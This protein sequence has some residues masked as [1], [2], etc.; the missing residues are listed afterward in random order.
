MH[1]VAYKSAKLTTNID[2]SDSAAPNV[3][4]SVQMSRGTKP[5]SSLRKATGDG[6]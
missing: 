3:D 5:A 4:S 1:T 2:R 6:G